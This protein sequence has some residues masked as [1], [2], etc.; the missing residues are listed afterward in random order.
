[1]ADVKEVHYRSANGRLVFKIEGGSDKDIFAGIARVQE[2]FEA[3]SSCGLCKSADITFRVRDVTK[4]NKTFTYHELRCQA[5]GGRFDFGQNQD[6]KS[7]FP[8]R[9][10]EN[11]NW[12]PNRGWYK[13]QPKTEEGAA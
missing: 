1:M 7:L 8:K 11:G 10:D 6:M 9:K 12:L 13:Y 2:T 3:D 5:C 4:G